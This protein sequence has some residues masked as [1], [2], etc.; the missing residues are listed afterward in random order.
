MVAP[1]SGNWRRGRV[2]SVRQV[3]NLGLGEDTNGS[4]PKIL[5]QL[6]NEHMVDY[7]AMDLKSA[8]T[9]KTMPPWLPELYFFRRNW[10]RSGDQSGILFV[11][12]LTMNS[13]QRYA[14]S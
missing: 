10:N 11:R 4:N 6:L 12:G 8:L 14:V 1:K 3:K 2:L 9:E 13:G 5:L 7:V